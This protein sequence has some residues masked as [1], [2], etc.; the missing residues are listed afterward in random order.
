[1]AELVPRLRADLAVWRILVGARI[2]SDWQYR[3][4]FFSFLVGQMLAAGLDLAAIAVIF[5]QVD[6]LG[7]W[8][9]IEVALLYGLSAT[10][11][12]IADV[13]VSQIETVDEHVRDGTFDVLLLRPVSPL[14]QISAME[15]AL[16][17][18][19]RPIQPAIVTAIALTLVDVDWT[20][21]TVLLV[22]LTIGSGVLLWAAVWTITNSIAFWTIGARETANSFTYGGNTLAQ[23]PIDVFRSW[24]RH[25][26][27][28]LLPVAFVAY[29]PAARLLDKPTPSPMQQSW[30]FLTPAVALAVT[31]V[32]V[33]VWRTGVRSYRSTGS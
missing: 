7:G 2:R 17:R 28:F 24:I 13:F 30:A 3:A 4:A 18:I 32:A 27:V 23:Y 8:S 12:S 15:F 1:M 29:L 33:L 20:P 10:G 16:R 14:L 19:G 26:V 25:L 31:A 9:G 11:F 22:P 5:G 21:A 6:S